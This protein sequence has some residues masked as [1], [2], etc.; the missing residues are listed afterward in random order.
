LK[1]YFDARWI[2]DHGI[3][4]VAKVLD[5]HLKFSHLALGGRP[6]S[7]FDTLRM[8][9]AILFRTEAGSCT[10]TPGYN[11]PLFINR[12]YVMTVH[13][14]NHIDRSEN[15][16]FLKSVYYSLIMRRACRNSNFVLTVSEFSRQRIM[17]WAGLPSERVVNIGNGFDDTYNANVLPYLPGYPYMLC[18]SN[19]KAHKN[20]PRVLEAFALAKLPEDVRLVLTGKSTEALLQQ[21]SQLGID[22]RVIFLGRVEES[23]LPSLYRGAVALLFPSLYEGFGLP[24]IE[25]MACGTPV[26][27]SNTTS[28]PEVAGDAAILVDPTSVPEIANGIQRLFHDAMLRED[29]SAKGLVQCA[30]FRWPETVRKVRMVLEAVR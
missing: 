13:D 24:V 7:P 23:E 16:G 20:E 22:G 29:L 21:A 19:R 6:S 28:L 15:G 17:D 18:V 3:G 1:T 4:R 5:E 25:A 26:L 2:G 30:Q 11:A 10:F 14:L 8:F 27:T 12:R 9:F